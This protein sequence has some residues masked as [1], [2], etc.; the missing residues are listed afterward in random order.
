MRENFNGYILSSLYEKDQ[1]KVSS[2]DLIRAN[3]EAIKAIKEPY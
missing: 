2:I 3:P 1:N